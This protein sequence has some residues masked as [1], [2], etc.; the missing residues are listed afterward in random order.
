[1][2]G[3]TRYQGGELVVVLISIPWEGVYEGSLDAQTMGVDEGIN[4]TMTSTWSCLLMKIIR[5]S[6]K[7]SLISRYHPMKL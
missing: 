1:L 4:M 2:V 6:V 7:L 3:P 5:L